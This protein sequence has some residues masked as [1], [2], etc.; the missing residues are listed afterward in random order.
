MK[1]QRS[2]HGKTPEQAA[3]EEANCVLDV[4][5]LTGGSS[6]EVHPKL[7]EIYKSVGQDNMADFVN[8]NRS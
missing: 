8:L 4:V 6:I 3:I 1:D 5:S 2:C 7:A